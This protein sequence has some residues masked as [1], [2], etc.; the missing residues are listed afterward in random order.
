MENSRKLLWLPFLLV[1][2]VL[3]CQDET[4]E[5]AATG[6]RTAEQKATIDKAK[7]IFDRKSPDFPVI[8]S[9]SVEGVEKGIV[10]EPVWGEAFV[11]KHN[12]GST[13]VETHIHHSKPLVMV[14]NA[15]FEAYM[16]TV[17]VRY[18]KYLSRVVVLMEEESIPQAFLMTIIGSKKYMESHDFQLWKVS[19]RNIPEDFSG[20]ILYHT[21]SGVFVNGWYVE[22][23]HK[24]STCEPISEEDASLL[25]RSGSNCYT[26]QVT[27][28]YVDCQDYAGYNY[29]IYEDD[30][31]LY[32]WA[33]STCGTPYQVVECYEVCD[34]DTGDGSG[35]GG[36]YLSQDDGGLSKY[37]RNYP[38]IWKEDLVDF[39]KTYMK[40][41][42]DCVRQLLLE[43]IDTSLKGTYVPF[44][45][46]INPEQLK[47]GTACRYDRV[48]N[49]V[50]FRDSTFRGLTFYEEL[51]HSVQNIIYTSEEITTGNLNMEFEAKFIIDYVCFTNYGIGNTELQK[52]I[53]KNG[54]EVVLSSNDTLRIGEWLKKLAGT[55]FDTKDYME[56]L[57]K[58]KEY[59]TGY[60]GRNCNETLTPKLMEGN[61]MPLI[62]KNKASCFSK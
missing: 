8:Q 34:D 33:Y 24:Y 17:D 40:S 32:T 56:Y 6:L 27:T 49:K 51:I 30:L 23:G 31:Y 21:L 42:T 2:I 1:A 22:E 47:D 44:D 38:N 12:D 62:T 26:Q 61:L 5:N 10:F 35:S 3:A 20:M 48:S 41:D 39:M 55:A 58:W 59:S 16:S 52:D 15:S 43:F 54:R 7:A 28:Y 45:I 53:N 46:E 36:G 4:A 14:S 9:R 57:K 11:A 50:Y 60:Q 37:V 18:L 13:T 29:S 19:Y 25:S